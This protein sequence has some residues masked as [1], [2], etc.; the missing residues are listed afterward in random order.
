MLFFK[1]EDLKNFQQNG[2]EKKIDE[3]KNNQDYIKV[4]NV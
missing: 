1:K 4:K 2:I 3:L